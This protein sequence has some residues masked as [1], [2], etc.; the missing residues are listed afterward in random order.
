MHFQIFLARALWKRQWLSKCGSGAKDMVPFMLSTMRTLRAI[1]NSD[2]SENLK[3]N[4]DSKQIQGKEAYLWQMADKHAEIS[5][6]K[7]L[8]VWKG[9]H[10]NFRDYKAGEHNSKT[11]VKKKKKKRIQRHDFFFLK[12]LHYNSLSQ[13]WVYS[14]T[15]RERTLLPISILEK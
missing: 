9:P 12:S 8:W 13:F 3:Y 7:N 14:V 4:P 6:Q 2:Q 1:N 15:A 11:E 10:C 5:I